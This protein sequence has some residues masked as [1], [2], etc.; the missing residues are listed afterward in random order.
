[1]ETPVQKAGPSPATPSLQHD[2]EAGH[3]RWAGGRPSR[4]RWRL[5]CPQ[6]NKSTPFFLRE[7]KDRPF[8]PGKWNTIFLLCYTRLRGT[9]W[10]SVKGI[11][12]KQSGSPIVVHSAYPDRQHQV[13]ASQSTAVSCVVLQTFS[14]RPMPLPLLLVHTV[15]AT[16]REGLP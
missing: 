15:L 7:E 12:I 14:T 13:P 3:S 11:H 9:R 1:M 6:S 8:P 10:L 16:A 2:G 5:Q 4:E